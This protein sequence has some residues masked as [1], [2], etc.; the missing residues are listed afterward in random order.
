MAWQQMYADVLYMIQLLI[1][2]IP[3]QIA[4]FRNV[5]LINYLS[6]RT[7]S[8]FYGHAIQT[9]GTRKKVFLRQERRRGRE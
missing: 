4:G 3:I 9:R 1:G 7:P 2:I 6:K 5:C 8:A